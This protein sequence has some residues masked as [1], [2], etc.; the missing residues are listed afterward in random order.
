MPTI[1]WRFHEKELEVAFLVNTINKNFDSKSEQEV[2]WT[3]LKLKNS[4]TN[5]LRRF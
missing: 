2:P 4:S 5:G 1:D 3:R